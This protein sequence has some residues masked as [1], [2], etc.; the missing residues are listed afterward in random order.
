MKKKI[1]PPED[2][3]QEVYARFL[4][5]GHVHNYVSAKKEIGIKSE[6]SE[7][8]IQERYT[9][10]IKEGHIGRLEDIFKETR[11]I[12]SEE[13]I[14]EGYSC[15][16]KDCKIPSFSRLIDASKVKPVVS[17]D[18]YQEA[19]NTLFKEN[20]MYKMEELKKA[21][22]ITVKIPEDVVQE[23]YL[24][25]FK[26]EH[27]PNVSNLLEATGIKP[28][29]SEDCIQEKYAQNLE[30]RDFMNMKDIQDVLGIKPN[31]S[32]EMIQQKY[33]DY[34]SSGN[35]YNKTGC[36]YNL[37][38]I[39]GINPSEDLVQK[40]YED[41]FVNGDILVVKNLKGITKINPELPEDAI[42]EGYTNLI[43]MKY[44]SKMGLI[45]NAL[46][47]YQT[48]LPVLENSLKG[49]RKEMVKCIEEAQEIIGEKKLGDEL[50][51][52]LKN[53]PLPEP[54]YAAL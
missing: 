28:D 27:M 45:A 47:C 13:I 52:S 41:S 11:I 40:C 53:L 15:F 31:F 48:S 54:A 36:V 34:L 37:K 35:P 8:F 5:D 24:S 12:P 14:Q 17:D 16:L 39:T 42:K 23:K 9:D 6:L 21:S 1:K 33:S 29:I 19:Y 49:I 51:A 46:P 30:D 44:S 25:N 7:E 20:N 32:N 38:E 50:I 18:Q 22:G 26:R 2:L 4:K 10:C 3:V 43:Q